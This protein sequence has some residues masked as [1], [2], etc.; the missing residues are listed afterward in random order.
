MKNIFRVFIKH[1][2][3]IWIISGIAIA[4]YWFLVPVKKAGVPSIMVPSHHT[5][6]K[7]LGIIIFLVGVDMIIRRCW[8]DT[9]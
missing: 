8:V 3:D 2:P 9:R 1:L 7:V 6:F 4:T 5:E